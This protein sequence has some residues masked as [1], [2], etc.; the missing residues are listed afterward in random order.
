MNLIEILLTPLYILF[1]YLIFKFR[2]RNLP[3]AILKRYHMR[4]F[5]VKMFACIMFV[6]YYTY[7][8]GGDTRSLYFAEGN[9]LFHLLLKDS[10]TWKYIFMKGTE[11]DTSLLTTKYNIGYLQDEANFLTIKITAV[12]GFF[13]FGYFTLIS[14]FFACFAYSGLWKLFMFFYE[15]RPNMHKAFAISILFFPSVIFWSSGI[16]KDSLCIGAL[17]WFT[18]SIYNI[19]KRRKIFS[20]GLIILISLYI[21]IVI[22]IYILLA[23]APFLLFFIFV[24]KLDNVKITPFKYIFIG[25]IIAVIIFIFSQTYDSY[26]EDLGAYSVENLTSQISTLNEI[27]NAQTG[28]EGSESNFNLGAEF[29]G[30]FRGMIKIAPLAIGATFYRPFIWET[31]KISQVMAAI[32]SLLLMFFTL[33]ILFKLGPFRFIQYVVSDP[34]IMFCLFFAI[35][36]A[37]FVGASTLNFG[38]LVR[39]KIPCMPF[40]CIALFLIYKRAENIQ[41]SDKAQL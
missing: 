40:Y 12:L 26:Q 10:S 18:F 6:I 5:W 30:T 4:G 7:F 2:G 13:T 3:N 16:L 33:K 36:F 41:K 31:R 14:L 39:Y 22:K 19:I 27:V 29:D 9:N 28:R 1:F 21:L 32:E 20:N 24:K 15:Q 34:M 35:V 37:L 25:G 23:Y 17:G 11:F 8:T 38:T